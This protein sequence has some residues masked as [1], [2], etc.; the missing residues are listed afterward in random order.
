L[1]T[2]VFFKLPRYELLNIVTPEVRNFFVEDVPGVVTE[3]FVDFECLGLV[4]G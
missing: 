4:E 3:E 2:D 1:I